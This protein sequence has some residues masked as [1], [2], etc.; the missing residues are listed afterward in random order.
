MNPMMI[1]QIAPQKSQ[2]NQEGERIPRIRKSGKIKRKRS[3][4][5]KG[6][7]EKERIDKDRDQKTGRRKPKRTKQRGTER[8]VNTKEARARRGQK[9]LGMIKGSIRTR[10]RSAE[11]QRKENDVC[12]CR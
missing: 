5:G 6:K 12:E 1:V 9:N 7:V 3:E 11:D 2:K 8:T 10:I 4:R